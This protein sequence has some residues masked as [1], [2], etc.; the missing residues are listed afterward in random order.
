MNIAWIVERVESADNRRMTPVLPV[1]ERLAAAGHEVTI[2][3]RKATVQSDRVTIVPL[4]RRGLAEWT[5]GQ[6]HYDIVHAM[7]PVA[8]ANVYQPARGTTRSRLA[9]TR[10]RYNRLTGSILEAIQA[11][12]GRHDRACEDA[13]FADDACRCI[14]PSEMATRELQESGAPAEHVTTVLRGV[15]VPDPA[16]EKR[17][18]DRQETRYRMN[19]SARDVLFVCVTTDLARDGVD[20]LIRG[21]G[22]LAGREDLPTTHLLC[23][24]GKVIEGYRRLAGL[25]DIG[26]RVHFVDPTEDVFGH[27]A[28]ADAVVQLPWHDPASRSVLEAVRWGLPTLTTA[29]DGASEIIARGAGV[30]VDS[31]SNLRDVT[32]GLQLLT[33]PHV[34][35]QFSTACEA[36]QDELSL[37][38]Y[39]ERLLDVYKK[40]SR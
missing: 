34:R 25:C 36:A 11:R 20:Y 1:A 29:F 30:V 6:E 33:D 38:R 8:G 26:N 13:L 14:G 5:A 19:L 21:L 16:S 12:R 35:A 37:N 39:V 28:A 9:A 3:C 7:T 40:V 22:K 4:G 24:G 32:D 2:F 17:T 23:L 10:R 18:H 15:D 27:Y 31:P